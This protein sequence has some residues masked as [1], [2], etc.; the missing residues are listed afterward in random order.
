MGWTEGRDN[1]HIKY[2]AGQ[3]IVLLYY[4]KARGSIAPGL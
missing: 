2:K 3:E 4:I 1:T